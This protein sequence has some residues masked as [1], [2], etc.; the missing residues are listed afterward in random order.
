MSLRNERWKP[1]LRMVRATASFTSCIFSTGAYRRISCTARL[2]RMV[3]SIPPRSSVILTRLWP[4]PALARM[5]PQAIL[6]TCGIRR[7]CSSKSAEASVHVVWLLLTAAR[8]VRLIATPISEIVV[9][10]ARRVVDACEATHCADASHPGERLRCAEPF[11]RAL[12]ITTLKRFEPF[13]HFVHGVVGD[14]LWLH[15]ME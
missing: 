12:G 5:I 10:V 11:P 9:F 2:P 13:A 1:K 7:T 4:G 14:A 3:S 15:I 8:A 6:L